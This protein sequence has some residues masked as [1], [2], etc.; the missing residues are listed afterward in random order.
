MN[1][2]VS[3]ISVWLV[4]IGLV[5]GA[6]WPLAI[7]SLVGGAAL[8]YLRL[9]AR[10]LSGLALVLG[11]S[12]ALLLL[13]AWLGAAARVGSTAAAASGEIATPIWPFSSLRAIA[14]AAAVGVNRDA[15]ALT[16]GLAIGD[17]SLAT[18]Q[19]LQDMK[20]VSLTHLVAV[21]GANCAIVVA[22]VYLLLRRF[23]I[24]TRVFVSLI[25]L[26]CYAALVGG[27]PSVLRASV[28][29]AAVLFAQLAGRK[30]QATA[31]L[32]L[33]IIVL[34]VADPTMALS[35]SFALSVA[36]TFGILL[37][38]P[39]LS[40]NLALRM[41]RSLALVLAVTLAAQVLCLPILLQLQP[42]LPTYSIVA[43]LICE[44]L[45]AP[46]TL[47]AIAAV[48]LSWLPMISSLLFWCASLPAAIIAGLAHFFANLPLAIVPWFEGVAAT[49]VALVLALAVVVWVKANSAS[50]RLVAAI[51]VALCLTSTFATVSNSVV[52]LAAWPQPD[53][54][55]ASCDVGQGDATVI[56]SDDR[57]ALIDVGRIDSK[58][59]TC[60][61]KLGVSTIDLLVLTH[62]D[63]DHVG[64]LAAAIRGRSVVTTMLTSFVDER[65]AA[66]VTRALVA[67]SGSR[68]VIAEQGLTGSLGSVTWRVLSPTRTAVEVEDSNDGS[69]TMLFRFADFSLIALADLGEKGQ[70]RLASNLRTWFDQW[71]EGHDLVMKVSHHGSADQY[72]EL[73]E[74]L[75][76][77]VALISVGK[78]NGYGHP[79]RRTLGLLERVQ[80]LICRTDLLGSVAIN[81]RDGTFAIADSGAS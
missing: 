29:A 24:K 32:S 64:A 55:I 77:A 16:L 12:L 50:S 78:N 39:S 49:A 51:T 66:A 46:I 56:R 8:L 61:A 37:L 81:R 45:V 23:S 63:F 25:V 73:L 69:V 68:V 76:P 54:Q 47:I 4:A 3:A 1:L 58:I 75:H 33:S 9:P 36:A 15:T 65:P 27:S 38:A 41:P 43:N 13:Q 60:L 52:K 57:F 20:T 42:G 5:G 53:W 19:L 35:Y 10:R 62:Y 44:P 67:G 6:W 17:S 11:S 34:L 7:G 31:I 28:M 70:M 18:P 14:T 40:R 71:V 59:D 48:S 2:I 21:S 30:S 26:V 72:A 79:T 22:A 74:Y 80:S